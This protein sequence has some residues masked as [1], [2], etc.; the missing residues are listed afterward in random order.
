MGARE[1]PRAIRAEGRWPRGLGSAA[2]P[3][4]RRVGR[5]PAA[6]PGRSWQVLPAETEPGAGSSTRDPHLPSGQPRGS[7]LSHPHSQGPSRDSSLHAGK[8]ALGCQ[9]H[10]QHGGLLSARSSLGT[11]TVRAVP[12]AS[13]SS[14]CHH[15]WHC[16]CPHLVAPC[17]GRAV[18]PR[19]PKATAVADCSQVLGK[20]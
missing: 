12:A 3:G 11:R 6:G 13:R 19:G 5:D 7:G 20:G 8:R 17:P 15:S 10:H 4:S 9:Q 18:T 14:R 1:S 16:C 2:A